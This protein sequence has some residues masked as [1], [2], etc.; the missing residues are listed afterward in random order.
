MNIGIIAL[1]MIHFRDQLKIYHWQTKNFARH[2]SSD[3][4]VD[5]ITTKLDKFIEVIQGTYTERI[6]ISKNNN[7]TFHNMN[8]KNIIELV[9]NFK[10]WLII[11]LPRYLDRKT[12]SDLFNIRDDI[13]SDVNQTL[14]LFTFQ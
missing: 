14:Y 6:V 12:D 2:K 8:D 4:L 3:S 9:E 1:K 7:F 10:K 5:N 13:L 11:E